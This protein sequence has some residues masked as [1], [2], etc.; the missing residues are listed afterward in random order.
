MKNPSLHLHNFRIIP[1]IMALEVMGA[2]RG[3]IKSDSVTSTTRH[4]CNVPS[5][6]YCPD[7]KPWRWAT[8]FV[9]HFGL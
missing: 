5:E 2:L 8:P 1:F 7:A 9:T 4:R 3:T 6:L